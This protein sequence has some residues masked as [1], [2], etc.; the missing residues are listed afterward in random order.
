MLEDDQKLRLL[1]AAIKIQNVITEL[2]L[3]QEYSFLKSVY[4]SDWAS[5][6]CDTRDF[7]FDDLGQQASGSDIVPGLPNNPES[8]PLSSLNETIGKVNRLVAQIN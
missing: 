1:L 8:F 6:Q 4:G 3:T 5:K 2:G 7:G